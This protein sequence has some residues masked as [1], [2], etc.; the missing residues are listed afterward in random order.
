MRAPSPALPRHDLTVV[1]LLLGLLLLTACWD[2]E[3]LQ[4]GALS[5]PIT[6]VAVDPVNPQIVY[7]ATRGNGVYK[8]KT[9]GEAWERSVNGLMDSMVEDLAVDLFNPNT[10][11][12]A[13]GGGVY[14]SINGGV[15]WLLPEQ[16]SGTGITAIVIDRNS[17]VTEGMACKNVYAASES[18]GV[19]KSTDSGLSWISMNEGLTET[20]VKSLAI[21]PPLYLPGQCDDVPDQC[22]D[23]DIRNLPSLNPSTTILYAGTEGGHVFKMQQPGQP[24]SIWIKGNPGLTEETQKEVLAIGVL[25]LTT[26]NILYAGT[27]REAG[28]A[29][30]YQSSDQGESWNKVTGLIPLDSVYV[31][32]FAIAPSG[33]SG[34][35]LTT[36]VGVNGLSK[37]IDGVNWE[38]I[39]ESLDKSTFSLAIDPL[40]PTI[41]YLG[42]YNGRFFKTV[43]GGQTWNF[44]EIP[45]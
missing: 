26:P 43:D 31:V 3:G 39:N 28:P 1:T 30:V 33:S 11:Y 8:S 44:I 17:C 40:D 35:I 16:G 22:E 41:M 4:S 15:S 13:T 42:S 18:V 36:Y 12:A 9:Y 2:E 27:G 23:Q 5:Y 37:S 19:Y 29:G 25:P 7:L 34:N 21:F 20:A 24:E 6:A 10:I 38:P 45:L 32:G 14:R